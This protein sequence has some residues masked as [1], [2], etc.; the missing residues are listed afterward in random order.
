MGGVAILVVLFSLTASTGML[1]HPGTW[2]R[3]LLFF[4]VVLLFG[5]IAQPPLMHGQS[6]VV[7]RIGRR[8]RTQP[9]LLSSARLTS[10]R[11][12]PPR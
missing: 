1:V 7:D 4:A 12:A 8:L 2:Q 10:G 11:A 9:P 3:L 5:L 6:S